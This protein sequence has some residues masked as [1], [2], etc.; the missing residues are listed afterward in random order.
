[1]E[2]MDRL[3]P[4]HTELVTLIARFDDCMRTCE[5]PFI[6]RGSRMW[7]LYEGGGGSVGGGDSVGVGFPLPVNVLKRTVRRLGFRVDGGMADM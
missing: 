6:K 3:Q 2:G 1:M 5:I 7:N 4:L